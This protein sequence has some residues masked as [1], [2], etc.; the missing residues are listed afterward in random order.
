MGKDTQ[1]RE[2]KQEKARL[3]L[4]LSEPQPIFVKQRS[5]KARG[6]ARESPAF[7]PVPGPPSVFVKQSYGNAAARASERL[8]FFV[9]LTGWR[10]CRR[11]CCLAGAGSGLPG[12]FGGRERRFSR[13]EKD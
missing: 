6:E 12:S 11:G 10:A 5:Q 13:R 8:P 9:R 4:A 1:R 7:P 2:A 3:S